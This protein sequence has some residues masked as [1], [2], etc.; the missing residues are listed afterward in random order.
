MQ[1]I[2]KR[3]K[4]ARTKAGLS[5]AQVAKGAGVTQTAIAELESGRVLRSTRTMDLARTVK[6]RPDWLE[7]GRGEMEGE[8]HEGSSPGLVPNQQGIVEIGGYEFARLPVFDIQLAA[9]A[10]ASN[11]YEGEEPVDYHYMSLSLLSS[12]TR[13]PV[14]RIFGVQVKGDSMEDTLHDRDWVIVDSL[15]QRLVREGIFALNNDGEAIVKRVQQH[16]ETHTVT[17]I[18]DNPKYPPQLIKKP[19]R[20]KVIGRVIFSIQR[21]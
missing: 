5:Q 12:I 2:G 11:P 6:V 3:L 10:G 9:G 17:L 19:E 7:N 4:Q 16:M 21:H 18:S 14:E 8:G 13:S 15:Q 1:G 20:L